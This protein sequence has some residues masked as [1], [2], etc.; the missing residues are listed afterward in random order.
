MFISDSIQDQAVINYQPRLQNLDCT[1]VCTSWRA[2]SEKSFRLTTFL[3][4]AAVKPLASVAG[5]Y[6]KPLMRPTSWS[7]TGVAAWPSPRL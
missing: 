7:E 3:T 6:P 5:L 2:Q 4:W 1:L